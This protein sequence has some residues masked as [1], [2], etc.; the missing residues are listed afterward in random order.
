MSLAEQM[1]LDCYPPLEIPD[2]STPSHSTSFCLLEVSGNF[3]LLFQ[4]Y[5]VKTSHNFIPTRS[6]TFADYSNLVYLL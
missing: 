5:I 2:I 4:W 3:F 6:V 1:S